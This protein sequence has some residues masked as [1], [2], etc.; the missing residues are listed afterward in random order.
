L[1]GAGFGMLFQVLRYSLSKTKR[2][3]ASSSQVIAKKYEVL[4]PSE[5]LNEATSAYEK[6]GE[7]KA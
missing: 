2:G 1:V 4:V 7:L 6:G 3:F 5:L